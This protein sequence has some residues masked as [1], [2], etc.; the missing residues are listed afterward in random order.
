VSETNGNGYGKL[1]PL[2]S[3]EEI[4][5][6]EVRKT[7]P[8]LRRQCSRDPR[9]KRHV[10]AKWLFDRLSDDSFMN[11]YGGDGF[12]KVYTSLIDLRRRYGHD[13][14]TLARWTAV[15]VETGWI[16]V[17][18]SWPRWCFGI[19]SVCRQPELFAPEYVRIMAKASGEQGTA[20]HGSTPENDPSNKHA[21]RGFPPEND[22][23]S[24]LGQNPRDPRLTNT[25]VAVGET[26]GR[27]GVHREMSSHQPQ[28]T[29]GFDR[30]SRLDPTQVAVGGTAGHGGENRRSRLVPPV[31]DGATKE[32]PLEPLAQEGG[33]S[34]KRSTM[35]NAQKAGGEGEGSREPETF[36]ENIRA[37][38][39]ENFFLL[40]VGAMMELWHEGSSKAELANSGAWWRV[41]FRADRDL[42][43]RVLDETL[44]AVKERQIK[45]TPGQYAVDLWK[46]W[47]GKLPDKEAP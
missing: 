45:Q 2:K 12:G 9:L 35:V 32:S 47:G 42:I 24:N 33:N 41:A 27:G 34:F 10:G 46:R 39:A 44:R 20:S 14:Q 36:E 11:I 37:K 4:A 6:D 19:T 30:E 43:Q 8:N 29:A 16:W 7:M 13:E 18:K 15:L 25:Q 40:D 21:G 38:K 26:A 22:K 28:V 31:S 23:T 1:E 17:Q 5:R 3:P